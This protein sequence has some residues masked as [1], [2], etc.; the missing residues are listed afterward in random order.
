MAKIPT[1]SNEKVFQLRAFLGLNENADGDSR[2]KM[3]EASEIH[4]W[5]ITRDGCLKRRPGIH[6][7]DEVDSAQ[8]G[9]AV[10]GMWS[11]WV[12]GNEELVV[13]CNDRLCRYNPTTE[14]FD[15]IGTVS[16]ARGRVLMFGFQSN[17]YIIDGAKYRVWDGTTLSDV[18]PYVPMVA[19][20]IPPEGGG[21]LMEQVNKLSNKRRVT[22]SPDGNGNTFYMPEKPI[23]DVT[24]VTDLYTGSVVPSANYT[25]TPADGS[26]TFNSV[27]TKGVE[28]FEVE[29]T[30][31]N[32]FTSQVLAM[33]YSE[34]YSGTQDTRVFLYGDGSNEAFYSGLDGNGRPCAEYFPDMNEVAV[35]DKNTPITGMIRHYSSLICY[36]TD[37]TWSISFGITTLDSGSMIPAFYCVPVNRNIG[38]VAVGQVQL[39]NNYPR[40]LH[41][42]D[43]YEW[44]NG[45]R[46]SGNLTQD[47]RQ[48]Q[49]I[50]DRIH[51]TLDGFDP[52][53][54]LCFDDNY[55]QEYYIVHDNTAL[56]HNYAVDAWYSYNDIP[57][58]MM[59]SYQNT[60]YIGGN[61]GFVYRMDE[62]YTDDDGTPIEAYW[63][64]GSMDFGQEYR[65]KNSA[66]LWLS[67]K[68]DEDCAVTVTI[69]TDRKETFSEKVVSTEKVRNPGTREP[70]VT[71]QKLK[72]KK[73]TS[74]KLIL[75]SD[76]DG[77]APTVC[78]AD[79]RVTFAGYTK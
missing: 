5:R 51:K 17:L 6:A 24:K 78:S 22:L 14:E 37:S 36:K 75:E 66:Q 62:E 76:G 60:L 43:L 11:G 59:V 63:E 53:E 55:H 48:A 61:D 68:P 70:L 34:L 13:A 49:R 38:N 9:T 72:A 8:I 23:V 67:M 74:Y 77:D 31:A 28:S 26:I 16:T 46:S 7:V 19:V 30:V 71:R 52:T 47:E 65:R 39:V 18:T 1:A 10:C 45:N 44:R 40:T 3:G 73:F 57:A 32:D 20:A 4:N 27:P 25:V 79:I 42:K 21:E 64:S 41:G 33:R 54:C 50:S 12:A 35:G 56:V 69:Q 2:L 15:T 29:Y 58:A